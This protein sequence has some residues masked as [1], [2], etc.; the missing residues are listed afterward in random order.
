MLWLVR[1]ENPDCGR[2]LREWRPAADAGDAA[3][4]G[5]V[6][7]ALLAG[8]YLHE[9]ERYLRQAA[10][11]GILAAADDLIALASRPGGRG[12]ARAWSRRAGD[13]ARR[14]G[15][16]ALTVARYYIDAGHYAGAEQELRPAV[17]RGGAEAA[18]RLASAV[19]SMV[20]RANNV[21]GAGRWYRLT[22]DRGTHQSA[23]L[24][25]GR[26]LA[27]SGQVPEAERYYQLRADQGDSRAALYLGRR[28][29]KAGRDQEAEKYLRMVK[30][31]APPG[32]NAYNL[33]LIEFLASK[34]RLDD[35]RPF[36]PHDHEWDDEAIREVADALR[37]AGCDSR[38]SWYE[39][40]ADER[41]HPYAD[42]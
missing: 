7:H 8:T 13:L 15:L 32:R 19:D 5:R 41:H 2:E 24:D 10:D 29:W 28:A 16:P 20:S 27:E 26:M 42:L 14:Q 30:P 37:R 40:R 38:A 23:A 3:A 9:A 1:L 36:L 25:L 17:E 4:A 12:D 21:Y 11:A 6:G 31:D 39:T 34:G 33:D 35:A 18:V 22:Y